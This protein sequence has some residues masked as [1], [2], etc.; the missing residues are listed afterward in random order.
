MEPNKQSQTS[1]VQNA[2]HSSK[3][4]SKKGTM[5]EMWIKDRR[6]LRQYKR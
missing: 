3:R 6:S 2:E 1:S 4:E 5:Q